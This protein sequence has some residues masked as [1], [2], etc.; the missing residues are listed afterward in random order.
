[1]VCDGVCEF[2]TAVLMRGYDPQVFFSA[3]KMRVLDELA[4]D[5]RERIVQV[6]AKVRHWLAQKRFRR[7]YNGIVAFLKLMQCLHR[8]RVLSEFQRR[9][10]VLMRAVRFYRPLLRRARQVILQR[11]IEAE[12]RR[13]EEEAVRERERLARMAIEEREREIRAAAERTL[14]EQIRFEEER[15]LQEALEQQALERS[16]QELIAA[17]RHQE[18]MTV[19]EREIR[20][21]EHLK[22]EKSL[23]DCR[24]HYEQEMGLLR[25]H[26]DAER[27]RQSEE[28]AK[29]L[30]ERDARVCISEAP[31]A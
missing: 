10:R 28:H 4:S 17:H 3:G 20:A 16:K 11:R 25:A 29:A 12:R 30:A 6:A 2:E 21:Q 14:R 26:T 1:M 9:V 7:A 18:E 19:L 24:V 5:S 13:K 23:H 27:V 31:C 15:R 22:L 8:V